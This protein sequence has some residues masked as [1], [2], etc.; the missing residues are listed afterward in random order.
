VGVFG[1]VAFGKGARKAGQVVLDV[2]NFLLPSVDAASEGRRI[3][4]T[5][6]TWKLVVLRLR[7]CGTPF[8]QSPHGHPHRFYPGTRRAC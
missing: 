5:N 2:C 7:L 6:I 8:L 1:G 4:E 3:D